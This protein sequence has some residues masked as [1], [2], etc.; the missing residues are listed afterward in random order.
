M[1][2]QFEKVPESANCS[3]HAFLFENENFNAPWHFHPEYELTFIIKGKG[4][5]YV[6]NSVENFEEGDFVLLGRNVPHCW[7]NIT[8]DDK[9]VKSIVIQFSDSILG[10]DWMERSEFKNIKTLLNQSSRGIKFNV[11]NSKKIKNKLNIILQQSDLEKLLSFVRLL[12]S[13]SLYNSM[14]FLISQGYTPN[15][16]TKTNYRLNK[17]YNYLHSNYDKKIRLQNV[18]SQVAMSDEAFCRFFKKSLNKSFFTFVNEYRINM[19][20]KQLI[21]TQR[22]VKQIAYSCGYESLPFFY[23]QFQKFKT[24]SPLEFRESHVNNLKASDTNK[25]II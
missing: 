17:V 1:K 16:N 3:F 4:I 21:E 10:I 11:E 24:C 15:L 2:A 8:T 9:S 5:R 19:V 12:E 23:R 14:K 6:G 25:I 18:S 13:L 22:P 20:C 7:K